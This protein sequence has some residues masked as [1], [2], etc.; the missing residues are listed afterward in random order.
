MLSPLFLFSDFLRSEEISVNENTPA[1]LN[2][3]EIDFPVPWGFRFGQ[4]S[5]NFFEIEVGQGG[6]VKDIVTLKATPH[7]NYTGVAISALKKLKYPPGA[8]GQ[9]VIEE[10][11][12][13]ILS[14]GQ[15]TFA[16]RIKFIR[17][18][19]SV[20]D[21]AKK[22]GDPGFYKV[23]KYSGFPKVLKARLPEFPLQARRRHVCGWV[24]VEFTVDLK[25][26]ARNIKVLDKVKRGL[27]VLTTVEALKKFRF[28]K[29]HGDTKIE[30][31][32]TY[33]IP[34]HCSISA[35]GS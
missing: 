8:A 20:G 18:G 7:G 9:K 4:P 17:V 32:V 21:L 22:P 24:R 11:D 1:P 29:G 15:S 3:T 35:P 5:R 30:Y 6:V 34:G 23:D 28:E 10:V 26:R 2:I 27:F 25:G 33:E 16:C 13:C 19:A 12:Y 31:L 14:D